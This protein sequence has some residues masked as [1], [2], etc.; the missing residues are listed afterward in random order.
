[1]G[2]RFGAIAG[3]FADAL[4]VRGRAAAALWVCFPAA[5]LRLFRATAGLF[6]G[7]PVRRLGAAALRARVP[8]AELAGRE[9]APAPVFF[10]AVLFLLRGL[11]LVA[12][13]AERTV[14]FV[15][16]SDVR[17]RPVVFAFMMGSPLVW[18]D[19]W[20]WLSGRFPTASFAKLG[21]RSTIGPVSAKGVPF[22]RAFEPRSGRG[23][24]P[25]EFVLAS[26][27]PNHPE[28][29]PKRGGCETRIRG[30]SN[31][32]F[33]GAPE[34]TVSRPV[35]RREVHRSI[36]EHVPHRARPEALR[37]E[38]A[39]AETLGCEGRGIGSREAYGLT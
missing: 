36:G 22:A 16:E 32:P 38:T 1:L 33:R 39:C 21:S 20:Q 2:S 24:G 29:S 8:A 37:T 31:L 19:G 25:I 3:R 6:A 26:V 14:C 23:A 10:E 5:G 27:P 15:A 28:I 4:R 30:S 7:E 11:L 13:F 35:R 9:A 34:P 18:R 17:A 12:A